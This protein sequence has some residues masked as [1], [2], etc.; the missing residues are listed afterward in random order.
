MFDLNDPELLMTKLSFL[1]VDDDSDDREIFAEVLNNI[2]ATIDCHLAE[3]A[4][5]AYNI[6]QQVTPSLIFLD[7]NMPRKNGWQL[8][9]EIKAH[10]SLKTIPTIMYS[11]SS[12]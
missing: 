10:E 11:T 2:D 9:S 4:E 1:L 5:M 7:I 8:L 6:L 12:H 3:D